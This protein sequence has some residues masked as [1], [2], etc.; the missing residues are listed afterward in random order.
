MIDED[1]KR[2]LVIVSLGSTEPSR[3]ASLV[4][5]LQTVLKSLSTESGHGEFSA[6]AL[7]AEAEDADV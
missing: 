2:F 3:I 4:P 5:S 6:P 7:R 1:T